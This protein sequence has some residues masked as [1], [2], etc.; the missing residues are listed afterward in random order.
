M[1]KVA[2]H[3]QIAEYMN[4]T[5]YQLSAALP[6]EKKSTDRILTSKRFMDMRINNTLDDVFW[7]AFRQELLKKQLGGLHL[8]SGDFQTQRYTVFL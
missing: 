3:K 8:E 1:W 4:K 7:V 5:V 2:K 6:S